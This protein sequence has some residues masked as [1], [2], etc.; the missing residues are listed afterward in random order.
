MAVIL[1]LHYFVLLA[2]LIAA[3]VEGKK[4]LYEVF[5]QSV[6]VMLVFKI[7]LL[8]LIEHQIAQSYARNQKF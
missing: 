1:R 4:D 8:L 2:L 3:A 5:M 6:L 7:P